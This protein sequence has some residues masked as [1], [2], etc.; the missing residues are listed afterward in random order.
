MDD[1]DDEDDDLN[2]IADDIES[3]LDSENGLSS[4]GEFDEYPGTSSHSEESDKSLEE[5]EDSLF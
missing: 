3:A 2:S 5:L 4:S 1:D